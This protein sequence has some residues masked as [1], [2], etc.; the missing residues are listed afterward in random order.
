[1]DD[2]G[3]QSLEELALTEDDRRL[4]AQPRH[5]VVAT[6]KRLRRANESREKERAPR[7]QHSRNRE[8]H[9]KTEGAGG[10]RYVPR[11]FLS[12]AVIA[13]TISCK[14]PITA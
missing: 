7:E 2:A 14:S 3:Q 8:R 13:G 6:V 1:M 5:D 9:G 10:G 12:S 4:V 11:T